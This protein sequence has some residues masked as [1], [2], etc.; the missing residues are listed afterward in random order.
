MKEEVSTIFLPSCFLLLTFDFLLLTFYFS[1]LPFYFLLLTFYFSLLPFCDVRMAAEETVKIEEN[2]LKTIERYNLLTREEKVLVGFSGGPDSLCL[3]RILCSLSENGVFVLKLCL[4]HVNHRL[5]PESDRDEE[6]CVNFARDTGLP[7]IVKR[8][9]LTA[10]SASASNI[11]EKARVGRYSALHEAAEEFGANK[12]AVAHTRDDQAETVFMRILRRSGLRGLAG[13]LPVRRIS[14]ES[15]VLLVRPLLWVS[16]DEVLRYLAAEKL[17]WVEDATNRDTTLLRNRIRFEI[18]PQI[19]KA[20]GFSVSESLA[21][22]GTLLFDMRPVLD[23]R[24]KELLDS[25]ARQEDDG[26]VQID[27]SAFRGLNEVDTY[28]LLEGAL[29]SLCATPKR[30]GFRRFRALLERRRSGRR[31]PLGSGVDASLEHEKVFITRDAR[32]SVCVPVR[33]LAVGE[34]VAVPELGLT[35]YCE[36]VD[37]SEFN[38]QGFVK[39]KSRFEEAVD[40][41]AVSGSLSVSLPRSGERFSPLGAGGSNKI[42]D[43]LIDRKVPRRIRA[44][45]PVVRDGKSVLWLVG[46]RLDERAKV[47]ESTK[48]VVIVRARARAK[49]ANCGPVGSNLRVKSRR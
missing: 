49:G 41:G 21:Q 24:A 6:F 34:E 36:S 32:E 11:E 31:V 2:V 44:V 3:T 15:E 27:L 26:T 35:F 47:T 7:I 8:L 20:C 39:E 42:S 37:A 13:I 18:L 12:V 28:L 48:K 1:L 16:R 10:K 19:E 22:L 38:L 30:S 40:A 25:L 14:P 5:R 17:N 4:C 23:A 46:H 43:F 29:N 9:D 45:T 33:H